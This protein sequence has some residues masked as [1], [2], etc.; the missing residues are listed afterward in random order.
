MT[1]FNLSLWISNLPD[2]ANIDKV[3]FDHL[4]LIPLALSCLIISELGFGF[5]LWY[6]YRSPDHY[7]K[8]LLNIL[9]GYLSFFLLWA[10]LCAITVIFLMTFCLPQ[11]PWQGDTKHTWQS[12]LARVNAALASAVSITFLLISFAAAL[13]HFQPNLYLEISHG[14]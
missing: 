13:R 4:I 14:G 5:Y 11:G 6:L 8:R 3:E 7:P 10:G 1:L 9:Y 2:F 12:V